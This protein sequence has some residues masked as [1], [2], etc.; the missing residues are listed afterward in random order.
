MGSEMCIRDS[1]LVRPDGTDGR[2]HGHGAKEQEQRKG[3][4]ACAGTRHSATVVCS[5]KGASPF[6]QM[7]VGATCPSRLSSGL[8]TRDHTPLINSSWQPSQ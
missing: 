6:V 3:E 2:G 1:A 8:R 4:G 5:P 7:A